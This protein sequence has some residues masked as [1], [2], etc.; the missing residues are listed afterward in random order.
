M[1]NN[2]QYQKYSQLKKQIYNKSIPKL[3]K[4]KFKSSIARENTFA[5]VGIQLGDEGK[6]RIVDNKIKQIISDKKIQKVYVVRSQGGNNA[7]HTVEKGKV[8]IGLHQLPSG[9]FY[10]QAVELLDSGMIIHVRDL[11]DEIKLAEAVAGKL[12]NR[13]ILSEDAMLCTDLDRA[14]EILN[15]VIDGK[16]K[17][18][19][20]RGMGPTAAGFF[21]KT[22]SFVKDLLNDNWRKVF[23]AKYENLGKLFNTYN[24]DLAQI[25]V[26][27][28]YKT[29]IQGKAINKT[30]GSQEEFLSKLK[31]DRED[32]LALKITKDTFYM[33]KTLDETLSVGI[34]FEMAQA[35]GLDP[36]F[37]TR[38][39]RTSTPTTLYGITAGTRYWKTEQIKEVTGVMKA[40]YMS[41]VG[42]RQMPTQTE[43]DYT[44]WI[45]DVAHEYGTTTGR[46]RD[47][48][49]LDIPFLLYNIRMSGINCLGITHLD[50]SRKDM[51]IK[52]C[53]AYTIKGKEIP[54][55]PD[56][57]MFPNFK[58]LYIEL[59]SWDVQEV[60]GI[61]EFKK[62]PK[63][64]QQFLLF[65]QEV[66]QLPITFA[67]TGSNRESVIIF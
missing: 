48:C 65:L 45:R 15:R 67:S 49:L 21:D 60:A 42:A 23:A 57:H 1:K 19:T 59:P 16:A 26:P 29:K 5:V 20:G 13:I 24:E 12:S 4:P 8:K 31:K 40:T 36:W 54:Y 46:P 62:L 27:D 18:G 51:P 22:G 44:Q 9:I 47:I 61:T 41:S 56:M 25:E 37:G 6:G 17:G 28:F 30:V 43:D 55:K 10:K 2:S 52:V 35:V 58:P 63:T 64:A 33:H 14:K 3:N 32:L 7:G 39:D 66:T 53:V 11:L 38:P 50:I 34:V